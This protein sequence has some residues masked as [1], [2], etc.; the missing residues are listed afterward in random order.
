MDN[1][2]VEIHNPITAFQLTVEGSGYSTKFLVGDELRKYTFD[3]T[4]LQ[5][6]PYNIDW[7]TLSSTETNHNVLTVVGDA[8]L[9]TTGTILSE[10]DLD[11]VCTN[12]SFG[13][14]VNTIIVG[15]HDLIKE[16]FSGGFPCAA[17]GGGGPG[18]NATLPIQVLS[19][20][21]CF[22]N[23]SAGADMWHNC[24]MDVDYL[25][26]ML[27]PW[28]WISG[29]NFSLIIVSLFVMFSYIKYHKVVYPILIGTLFLPISYFI[30]PDVF[31]STAFV[32][33]YLAMGLVLVFIILKQTKEY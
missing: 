12:F 4:L 8:R 27:L 23:F 9:R 32:L 3:R 29:G 24:G 14:G 31:L 13:A 18:S 25:Q 16:L 10:V 5:A 2:I 22:L 19:S 33:A 7:L 15:S 30:F 26:F 1:V 28:E 17:G 21:P 20:G 6:T 11:G